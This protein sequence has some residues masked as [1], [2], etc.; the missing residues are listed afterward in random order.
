[1]GWGGE[2]KGP[3]LQTHTHMSPVHDGCGRR[4]AAK[5]RKLRHGSA[6]AGIVGNESADAHAK[7]AAGLPAQVGVCPAAR[8]GRM[9]PR[10]VVFVP[11]HTGA[12][13]ARSFPCPAQDPSN[14]FQTLCLNRFG[15]VRL[16]HGLVAGREHHRWSPFWDNRAPKSWCPRCQVW[17]QS[18]C[19]WGFRLWPPSPPPP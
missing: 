19:T 11:P 12:E 2:G 17:H 8:A 9:V 1:M 13:T 6:H 4:L 3:A 16:A 10:W 18:V 14:L 7:E 5:E 15:P